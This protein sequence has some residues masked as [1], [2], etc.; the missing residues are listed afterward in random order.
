MKKIKPISELEQKLLADS[1]L[2]DIQPHKYGT[3]II[4]KTV[5]DLTQDEVRH[6]ISVIARIFIRVYSGWPFHNE[7]V[8]RRILCGLEK[9][10]DNATKI[11]KISFFESLKPIIEKIPDNHIG[12]NFS[13]YFVRTS[14]GRKYKDV[15]QNIATK[16]EKLK[17]EKRGD[18]LIVGISTLVNWNDTDRKKLH[19]AKDALDASNGLIIDFRGNGGGDTRPIQKLVGYLYGADPRSLIKSYVRT[20]PEAK[21]IYQNPTPEKLNQSVDPTVFQNYNNV[22]YP[23]FGSKTAGYDKPIYI[24]TDS[25][26]GSSAESC[27]LALMHHPHIRFVGDNTCGV[28]VFGE[29]RFAML[30][31]SQML[32]KVGCVYRE[33]E[34]ENFE[35]KGLTPDIKVA[36]GK[37]ALDVAIADFEQK[38][39]FALTNQNEKDS[40]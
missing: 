1:T 30:P 28:E 21:R 36:E 9:L 8:K 6:D 39:I 13:K 19:D 3:P 38:R 18:M 2:D 25:Y 32:F 35:L 23:K 12:L 29:A 20:T 34:I 11:S 7:I 22:P 10:Y 40:R 4:Y 31:N 16:D 26:T 33:L 14:L 15:G 17:I 27:I 5:N 37:D 24:L